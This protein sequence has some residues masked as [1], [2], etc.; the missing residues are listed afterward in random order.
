MSWIVEKCEK[1]EVFTVG[2]CVVGIA[3]M[4]IVAII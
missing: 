3:L 4:V 2:L 1:S